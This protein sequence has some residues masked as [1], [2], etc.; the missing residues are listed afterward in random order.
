MRSGI[1]AVAGRPNVGKWTL[2]NALCGNKVAITPTAKTTRRRIFGVANWPDS[3][4]VLVNLPGFQ[5]PLDEL[6]ERMQSTVDRA[7]ADIEAVLFVVSARDRI[8]AGDRFV[9]RRVFALGIPV[10]IAL[11]KINRLKQGHV[12]TQM[13]TGSKLGHF[14]ALHPVSAETKDGIAGVARGSRRAAPRRAGV[15]PARLADRLTVEYRSR[16]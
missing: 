3:Q 10:M 16:S 6:T 4:L 5:R 9:A 8:G 12:A 7:F 2:V 1:V 14:H 13:T 15:L 11:N